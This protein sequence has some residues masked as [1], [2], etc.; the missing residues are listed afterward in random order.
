MPSEELLAPP[1]V[2]PKAVARAKTAGPEWVEVAGLAKPQ[3]E[4]LLDWLE[5]N[6]FEQRQVV[7]GADGSFV[8]RYRPRSPRSPL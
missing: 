3:A 8:V 4:Q 7:L 6:G 5:V 1:W 2:A